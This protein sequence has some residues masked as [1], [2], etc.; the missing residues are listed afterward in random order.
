M[1]KKI[2]ILTL[3]L[4]FIGSAALGITL[5]TLTPE[6][7]YEAAAE[8]N[9]QFEIN[10][11]NLELTRI[12]HE[13]NLKSASMLALNNY[14]GQLNKYYNPF[15]SETSLIAKERENEKAFLQLEIDI[16]S[17][18]L[19]LE[20]AYL[21]YDEAEAAYNEAAAA[22]NEAAAD[23]TVPSNDVLSLKYTME[24]LLISL[25]QA[26]NNL[27]SAQRNMDDLIGQEGVSV[28]L[29][30][31]YSDPY[32]ID[33]DD[34]FESAL[35]ADIGI[36]KSK[37]SAEAAKIKFDI[38]AEYYDEDE[39]TYISA[40]AGLIS[41]ED[42]YEKALISLEIRVL[43]DIDNL[44]TKYDSISLAELNVKIKLNEYN[45]A[46]K[47]YAA[48]VTSANQLESTENA[49]TTSKKQLDSKI[50]DFILSSMRFAINYGYEF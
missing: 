46:K 45:A 11:L 42:S 29:P 48:G 39:E 38:A 23:S 7:A 24:S 18:A 5:V 10:E 43:D 31:E 37:R 32:D 44:K 2:L 25:R 20:S 1:K 4:L 15:N 36:Y 8:N 41:A 27:E 19:G 49:Y 6:E 35:A 33:P 21:A 13:K 17:A 12:A 40:L 26:E 47:Q 28:E 16:A 3:I 50:H 34:A 9:I 30:D 22:Y 14:Y